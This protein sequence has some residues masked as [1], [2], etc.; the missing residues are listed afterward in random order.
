MKSFILRCAAAAGTLCLCA[1]AATALEQPTGSVI[2]TVKGAI[3]Q[4]N[5]DGVAKFDQ[6]MLAALPGREAM[7]K[8]P[9]IEDETRFSG[10]YLRAV[11]DEVG[12]KGSKLIVRAL[13]DYAAE[14]P[15]S[16][17]IEF[18]TILAIKMN[19]KPMSVRE[20]GPLFLIYPFDTNPNLYNEKYFTRSVWQIMEIEVVE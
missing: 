2:L 10:P 12:S 18:D 6:A 13:N 1:N 5:S 9:W 15:A 17:A 8:T 3:T 7:M 4:T 11:L 16:D 20:K 19:G 14:V